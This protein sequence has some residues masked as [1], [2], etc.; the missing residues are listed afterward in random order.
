[1]KTI[2]D[3]RQF[4]IFDNSVLQSLIK[5]NTVSLDLNMSKESFCIVITQ[6]CDIVHTPIEEDPYIEFLIGNLSEDKSCKNCRNPRKLHLEDNGQ[7]FEFVAGNKFFIKKELLN[8]FGFQGV[9]INLS[10]DN[11][12]ILKRWL[13]SRYTRASFPNSFNER[14]RKTEVEKLAYRAKSANVTHIFFE[15]T[16]AELPDKVPYEIN[17]MVVTDDST[18]KGSIED[19]YFDV[20]D[21]AKTQGIE[22]NVRIVTEDEVTLS[23]LKKYKRWYV[24]SISISKK[25]HSSPVDGIDNIV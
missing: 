7:I 18:K 6:D 19:D 10:D 16:D 13:G 8:S 15:V 23:D 20:F 12:K 11:K 1:M 5:L 3:L 21:K 2:N 22:A 24:D 17:V 4:D 9:Y 25:S 14:L